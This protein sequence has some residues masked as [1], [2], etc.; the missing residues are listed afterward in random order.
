MIPARLFRRASPSR[1]ENEQE[2]QAWEA[3]IDEVDGCIRPNCATMTPGV[4]NFDDAGNSILETHE[5]PRGPDHL[6]QFL[7]VGYSLQ[8]PGIGVSRSVAFGG[9]AFFPSRRSRLVPNPH[10]RRLRD[11]ARTAY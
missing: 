10:R 3:S 5:R 1:S 6:S 2:R 8:P 11:R 9:E 4:A 7:V